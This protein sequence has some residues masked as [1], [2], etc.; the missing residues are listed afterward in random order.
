MSK[1]AVGFSC[2]TPGVLLL[3][4]LIGGPSAQAQQ[5]QVFLSGIA[6]D[7]AMPTEAPSPSPGLLAHIPNHVVRHYDEA[8]SNIWFGTT[9]TAIRPSGREICGAAIEIQLRA[10]ESDTLHSNDYLEFHFLNPDGTPRATAWGILLTTLG[11]NSPQQTFTVDLAALPGGGNLLPTLNSQDFLDVLVQDDSAVDYVKLTV[12]PCGFDVWIRDNSDDTGVEPSSNPVWMS[13][14]IRVCPGFAG[15]CAS[16]VNPTA[17]EF[18]NVYVTLRNNGPLAPPRWANGTLFVYYSAAGGAARWGS[19]DWTLIGSI[20]DVSLAPNAVQDIELP[21]WVRLDTKTHVCLLAR[22]VSEG[23][24]MTFPEVTNTLENARLNNNIA[25]KNITVLRPYAGMP[26]STGFL[27]RNLKPTQT[28]WTDLQVRIPNPNWSFIKYGTLLVRLT[29][30]LWDS[31]SRQG[32]GFQIVGTRLLRITDPEG[33]WL[34]GLVL[35]PGAT[36]AV[37]LTFSTEYQ[38]V[39]SPFEVQVIQHDRSNG[40]TGDAIERGGVGY[41]I[42][43]GH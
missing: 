6:D 32:R 19:S 28:V 31:W 3:L 21:W 36:E 38:E 30:A 10:E 24:P 13:P 23:D 12:K 15:K 16:H 37:E 5:E 17:G 43:I 42:H 25:W 4:V 1:R 34:Q 7:F 20:P 26:E 18:N 39:P 40:S 35:G 27:L 9:F 41:Q 29:P 14:D 22:W 33:A 8:G 11:M 2:A